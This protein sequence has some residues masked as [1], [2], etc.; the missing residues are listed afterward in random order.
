MA[1]AE[2]LA[3]GR[4]RGCYRDQDGRKQYATNAGRL[5]D[6]KRAA[7]EAAEDAAAA[8]RRKAAVS[9][10]T[11]SAKM[12]WRH[13]WELY[14]EKK[15]K[16][17]KITDTLKVEEDR[18]ARH[19]M[20][21]WGD[22]PLNKIKHGA[23][24]DW[25]D[26]DLV[27]GHAPG[28]VQLIWY[29]F[30]GSMRFAVKKR[31]ID[32]SPCVGIE[33]P[34]IPTTPKKYLTDESLA[35]MRTKLPERYEWMLEFQYE[36]GL[37]PEELVAMHA[38]QV[39]G[40]WLTVSHVYIESHGLIRPFTKTGGIRHVPLTGRARELFASAVGD[41]DLTTGCGVPHVGGKA[42]HGALAFLS[43]W[44]Q[45]VKPDAYKRALWKAS[46]A[47]GLPS[48]SPYTARRGFAT[49]AAD[50][51]VNPFLIQA[52]MGHKNLSQT[53]DYVQ[54]SEAS[55]RQFL[56]AMGDRVPLSVV[57]QGEGRGAD[58]GAHG[59]RETSDGSGIED[60]GTGL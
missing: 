13:L 28:Y 18:V 6:G 10:G 15:R 36:T 37:R 24:Q 12:P 53:S 48:M 23:A 43:P 57:G 52:V 22:V 45:F 47:V 29:S 21:R 59:L 17:G 30:A 26:D 42:C 19:V 35:L 3:S 1:W 16:K 4:W 40:G 44:R 33:L 50:R 51:G 11:Q 32:A 54:R 9:A 27:P 2:Q 56:A 25:V 5:Y 46:T 60:V 55:K 8:S 34:D 38:A 7:K 31:I 20:P 14:V 58:P 39:D 49:K 41:R